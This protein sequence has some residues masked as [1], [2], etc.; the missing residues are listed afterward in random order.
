MSKTTLKKQMRKRN[1]SPTLYTCANCESKFVNGVL[2]AGWCMQ[3]R[4]NAQE[5]HSS[6][7]KIL[8]PSVEA[9]RLMDIK[10]WKKQ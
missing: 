3:C 1:S 7:E 10:R 9:V 4:K 6:S 2:V 5:G 8:T